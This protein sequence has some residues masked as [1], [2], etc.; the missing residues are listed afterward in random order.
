MKGR[1]FHLFA[2]S[3]VGLLLATGAFAQN[4]TGTIVGT[5]KD[6][7]GAVVVNASVSVTNVDTEES[8]TVTANGAGEYTA[9]LLKPG[10]YQVVVSVSGFKKESK[11]GIVL[12][13]DQ[14]VRADFSL[15][16]GAT[17]E[18]ISISAD[19][20]TLDTEDASVGELIDGKDINDLPLFGRNFQDLMFLAPGA[21]NNPGGEEASYRITISG[22]ST[23]TVSIGG[24]RG[25]SEG[26][27]VDGTSIRDVG[28]NTPLYHPS[29]DDV[30]QF[31]ELSKSYSA[32]YGYSVNQINVISRSGT[33]SYHGSLFEYLHNNYVDGIAHGTTI[34]PGVT[35][36]PQLRLNQFG[37]A[38]GG[39]VRIPW[40]YN[41]RN[42][43]FFFANYEGYRQTT[44]GAV[45]TPTSVPTADE[46]NGKFDASVL[47][48]F[49][50]AQLG[51]ASS[52][53]QCGH[54]YHVGDA[55]PL[56]NPWDPNGCPFTVASDGSYTIPSGSISRLG[57]L[58]MRPGLY[59]PA[60]PNVS[61][62]TIPALNYIYNANSYLNYDQQNYRIDQ[63]I[64]SRDQIFFHAVKHDEFQGT[65][66]YI[67]MDED[68]TKQPARV[69]TTTE[70]HVFSP[71]FTNQIR[72]GYSE[73]LWKSGPIEPIT[74]ADLNAI[75]F[76]DPFTS[77]TEGYPRIEFDSS[78]LDDGYTYGGGCCLVQSSSFELDSIWDLG[79]SAIWSVK[80]HTISFGFGGRHTHYNIN[81][82]D[83]SLGRIN[84]NGEYSGDSF[85]DAIMGAGVAI[86]L[87]ELGPYSNPNLGPEAHLVFTSWAPYVQDDWK[88]SDKLTLNFGLRYEFSA[89][90]YEE[91]NFFIWPDFNA[92]GGAT[93]I[94]NAKIAHQF[95][96]V[97]P[98]APGTGLY[99]APPNGE[100]GPG[101][102]PKDGWAPRLG[103][104]YRVF[105]DDKTVL[106]GG[107]GK[108]FDTIEEDELQ[109][110][111]V[112]IYPNTDSI[113]SGND[114]AQSYPAAYNTNS[115]PTGSVSG[116]F[117]T[118]NLGFIQIQGDHTLNPYY[119][120]WNLGV[121]RQLPWKNV[122]SVDY[123]ANHGTN[124][125]SRYNPNAPSECISLNGCVGSASGSSV[126]YANRVPYANYG[127]MI[128]AG[129]IGFSNY[130]GMNVE[131]Q[132]RTSDLDLIVAYTWS[133]ELD[134]KSAVAGFSG[135]DAGWAGPQ[136]GLDT[137]SDYG[138]GSFD[139]GNELRITLAYNLPI[140]R[141][142]ALLGTAPKAVDEAVG[143]WQFSS[144][145]FFQGG[146]P[147]TIA[148]Q[149]YSNNDTD[150][151]RANINPVPSGFHR[152]L[153]H[154][155]SGDPTDTAGATNYQFTQPAYGYYGT[156]R[157]DAIRM[158]GQI[159]CDLSLSKSFPIR[160]KMGFS[161]RADAFNA[162]NHWNPGQPYNYTLGSNNGVLGEIYPNINTQGNAR[163]LQGAARFTF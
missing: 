100:R 6:S 117:S 60:A 155:F 83:A 11:S 105:G 152:S 28:Y 76:P 96:G 107:F 50:S 46:M 26:Y 143:G 101:P 74:S 153:A 106:R 18:T 130:Q 35:Q 57:K 17:S 39:P 69:Y 118:A 48:T 120:A 88:V 64:G 121:E 68:A 20:L 134:T 13:V 161:V 139:V 99:V 82:G 65:G 162:F 156:S 71:S 10:N 52:L 72:L 14:T 37:Y 115:L 91:Q 110:S 93:Y 51:G 112:G 158:P 144:E 109:A 159:G 43:T 149:D 63:N 84:Y 41:G 123:V 80:R 7:T 137:A 73:G 62:V 92:P 94:A 15:A 113:S 33:N 90:P 163:I 133:K 142:K 104:A 21:V 81:I 75:Q 16:A 32:A 12:N 131:L 47:G 127:F 2:L 1:W 148:A 126:P 23:S 36:I 29:L 125:Y 122:L 67:A 70:T 89:T 97:N 34:T 9:P 53:T 31:N 157:R 98:L 58:V 128:D 61:G 95:G 8:R 146:L 30:A 147:F 66:A 49:T 24:S 42:K 19:A 108:Y 78:G 25:S 151:E 22:E 103:F 138:L 44:A 27:T 145:T 154:W 55:H 132:H 45:A 38:L 102:A 119:L 160:E 86:N 111:S 135:D 79:E 3:V 150:S 4:A 114:A 140:G 129:F 124:L 85:A 141:G 116:Q 59:Y 77:P 40:L 5:V 56:F 87:T 54:T 136:N